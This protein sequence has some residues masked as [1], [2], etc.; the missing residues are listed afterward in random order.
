MSSTPSAV[1]TVTTSSARQ[2]LS[3]WARVWSF[4]ASMN[5]IRV[6]P[7]ASVSLPVTCHI[8]VRAKPWPGKAFSVACGP[9]H[10]QQIGTPPR[11]DLPG[12]YLARSETQITG[13]ASLFGVQV[14]M[15]A[16]CRQMLA[17]AWALSTLGEDQAAGAFDKGQAGL[18]I[19]LVE[20]VRV[21]HFGL[22]VVFGYVESVAGRSVMS[23]A[24]PGLHL[25]VLAALVRRRS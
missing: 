24:R 12:P 6:A 7:S 4:C 23:D 2:A 18:G 13:S 1:P 20:G 3:N 16:P 22:L 10:G 9:N 14:T 19:V 15:C 8:T 5:L 17:V 11:I 21:L 25:Y